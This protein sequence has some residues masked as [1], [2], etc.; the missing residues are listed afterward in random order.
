V[1]GSADLNGDGTDDLMLF[2][3]IKG[4]VE[5]WTFSGGSVATRSR[6][7]GHAGAWSV[8]AVDDT[9]GDGKAEIVWLD[10]LNRALELRDP[11]RSSP[12][13]LG[14]LA[15]GWRVR[16]G[17]DLAGTGSADLVLNNTLSVRCRAGRST[18]R[19]CSP[20]AICPTRRRASVTSRA[21]ATSTAT[22]AR[23]SRGAHDERRRHALAQHRRHAGGQP[24]SAC[25]R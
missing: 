24:Q 17:A 13:N 4:E 19:A 14:N 12:A 9:D 20:R 23:T 5:V 1:G 16:G 2:S 18:T 7:A 10:E 11:A 25:G 22:A 21:R 3:R 8:A 15:A 6:I